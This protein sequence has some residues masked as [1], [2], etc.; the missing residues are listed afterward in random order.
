MLAQCEL[1]FLYRP[2]PR[3]RAEL[4][5]LENLLGASRDPCAVNSCRRFGAQLLLDWQSDNQEG[6][7]SRQIPRRDQA[8]A[9]EVVVFL[10]GAA[11]AVKR[12]LSRDEL[13]RVRHPGLLTRARA[14]QG[15]CAPAYFLAI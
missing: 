8:A 1:R 5:L 9:K 13:E 15:P 6:E 14:Y 10:T 7:G 3:F 11:G 12:I 4:E 2:S